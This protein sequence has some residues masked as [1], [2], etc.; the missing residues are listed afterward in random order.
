[1]L[2]YFTTPL[3]KMEYN[4]LS[5]SGYLYF[6]GWHI[7]VVLPFFWAKLVQVHLLTVSTQ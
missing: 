5:K 1:M 3:W 4:S 7:L 6:D 2:D